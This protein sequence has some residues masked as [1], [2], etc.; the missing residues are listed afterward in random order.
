MPWSLSG[1]LVLRPLQGF[2]EDGGCFSVAVGQ[3]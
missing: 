1:F 3:V 2:L